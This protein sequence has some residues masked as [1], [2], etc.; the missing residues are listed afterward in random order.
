MLPVELPPE[1]TPIYEMD[2]MPTKPV[3]VQ[4]SMPEDLK[5]EEKNV[6]KDNHVIH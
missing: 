4:G 3:E 6:E 5:K 1:S 2:A